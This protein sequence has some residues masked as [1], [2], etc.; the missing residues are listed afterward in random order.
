M[1][2]RAYRAG[3]VAGVDEAGRG[4]LA[5]PVVAASVVLD[6]RRPIRGLADSKLL[7]PARRDKLAQKI[8]KRA[9]CYSIAWAD[10][11]EIDALNILEATMLAMRRAVGGLRIEPQCVKIDGNRCPDLGVGHEAVA[12]ESV[13]R[14]DSR[15]KAI[16]A[17][18]I[19]AKVW[20]DDAMC[21]FAGMFPQYGFERH[22]GYPTAEHIAALTRHGPCDL[23][24]MS[25][26]PVNTCR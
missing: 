15:V 12:L 13:V 21:R 3:F 16:S 19:L 26:R 24:R 22:K 2:R 18:S 7:T 23:H 5:G 17:A 8:V 1:A 4:P 11:R 9:F 14:G 25:F 6:P 10:P 20:R